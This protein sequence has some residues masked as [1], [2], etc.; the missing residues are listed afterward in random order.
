MDRVK[1]FLA[2]IW[3]ATKTDHGRWFE[4]NG[5]KLLLAS[6]KECTRAQVCEIAETAYGY[7]ESA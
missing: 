3:D 6:H 2:S 5:V 1:S 4:V 7:I